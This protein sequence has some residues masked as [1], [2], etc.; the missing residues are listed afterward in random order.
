MRRA[1]L[2]VLAA[3]VTLAAGAPAG[4]LVVSQAWIRALAPGIPAAGYFTLANQGDRAAKLVGAASPACGSLTL[5][6]TMAMGATM[7]TMQPVAALTVP[8]HGSVRF[9]PGGYHLMCEQAGAAVQPGRSIPVTFR[10][11]D[12]RSVRSDFPVRGARG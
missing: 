3:A 8:P 11:D 4:S 9:A 12:G 2:A 7:S 6:R 10:F 1:G 5:H